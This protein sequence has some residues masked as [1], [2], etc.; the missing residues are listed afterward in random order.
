MR[1]EERQAFAECVL[2]VLPLSPIHIQGAV[3]QVKVA[4]AAADQVHVA[5]CL[6]TTFYAA[7]P[8]V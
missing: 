7:R 4:H 5:G 1:R 6:A 8:L 2:V 3:E